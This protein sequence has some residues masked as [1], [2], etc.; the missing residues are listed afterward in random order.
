MYVFIYLF[1]FLILERQITRLHITIILSYLLMLVY[2]ISS[3]T[4]IGPTIFLY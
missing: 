2:C 4:T 1:I 3:K